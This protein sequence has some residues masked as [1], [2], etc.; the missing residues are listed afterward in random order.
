MLI[1]AI[2]IWI[3]METLASSALLTN[4]T[5]ASIFRSSIQLDSTGQVATSPAYLASLCPPPKPSQQ[6]SSDSSL[7]SLT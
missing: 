1:Y 4:F 2:K 3:S 5:M 6:L 7:F